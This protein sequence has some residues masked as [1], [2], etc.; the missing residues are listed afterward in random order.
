LQDHPAHL[1]PDLSDFSTG[2]YLSDDSDD[3]LWAAAELW[4]TTGDDEALRD[5]EGRAANA[6]VGDDWEWANLS[7]LALF[8]YV[9]R[10]GDGRSSDVVEAIESAVVAS[11]DRLVTTAD[12]H[13]FLRALGD[14]YYW[15]ANG[16]VART[17]LNLSVAY[18]LTGNDDYRRTALHQLDH[19]FGLNAQGRSFVTGL[20]FLPP[21]APH[22]R[23]SGA[24]GVEPPWPGLLVGGPNPQLPRNDPAVAI[25]E[26]PDAPAPLMWQDEQ[27]SY[28]SNEIAVNWNAP[29][30]YGL[31]WFARP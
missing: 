20:G 4:A 21:L 1:S 28:W 23:P 14:V 19:L 24:D 6:V 25:V 3:R 17:L 18:R 10:A 13:P 30:V 15:G 11:A 31:A 9:S 12:G 27:V 26:D 29:L 22:H 16:L 7:N 8:S 5:F 2:T